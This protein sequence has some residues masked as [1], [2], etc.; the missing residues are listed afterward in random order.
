MTQVGVLDPPT[1]PHTCPA[2]QTLPQAPQFPPSLARFVQVPLQLVRPDW[3]E[4]EQL[5]EEQT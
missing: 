2:P 1:V 4:S 5:P 3:Q